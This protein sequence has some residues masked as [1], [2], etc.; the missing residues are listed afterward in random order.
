M[1]AAAKRAERERQHAHTVRTVQPSP[2]QINV[3][4]HHDRNVKL[5]PKPNP[6]WLTLRELEDR[7]LAH[8]K[9]QVVFR[10]PSHTLVRNCG[11]YFKATLQ[12]RGRY[13]RLPQV[14]DFSWLNER[15]R[16]Y[17][18]LPYK[19]LFAVPGH[20]ELPDRTREGVIVSHEQYAE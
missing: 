7:I 18:K 8:E 17:T 5:P 14:D 13:S 10:A 11:L 9:V 19:V 12:Q 1:K 20:G 16:R 3:L 15:I 4:G 6:T 2:Q